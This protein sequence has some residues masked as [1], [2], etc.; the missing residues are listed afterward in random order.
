MKC[1][2]SDEFSTVDDRDDFFKVLGSGSADKVP[3]ESAAEEDAAFETKDAAAVTLY[4]VT[5]AAG[6][7]KVET[8]STKPIR[9]E[10]LKSEVKCAEVQQLFFSIEVFT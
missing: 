5:D 9:Q 8:I 4:K 2:F 10:M 6:T 1:G 3:D 7:L